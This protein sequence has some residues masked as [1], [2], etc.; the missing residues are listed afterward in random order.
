[1]KDGYLWGETNRVYSDFY[2]FLKEFVKNKIPEHLEVGNI[3]SSVN[4]KTTSG[5]RAIYVLE[6]M[7]LP[8]S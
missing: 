5:K 4:T 1:V 2:E 7:I 3:S 6:N 8:H